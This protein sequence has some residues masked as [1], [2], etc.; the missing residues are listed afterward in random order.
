MAYILGEK[1]E[2]CF[3]CQA[4]AMGV[5]EESL[6]LHVT[7][8]G[9]VMLNRYP[10]INGHLMVVPRQH[11]SNLDALS[12]DELLDLHELLRRTVRIVREV[13]HPDGINIGMNLG[14]AAGAGLE[15]H[16]HYHVVP[17]YVGDHNAMSVLGDARV[18]PE[19]LEE[20]FRRYLAAFGKST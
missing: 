12:R 4:L 14:R 5:G 8:H 17:R 1:Q 15:D 16:L 19:S 3:V 10:Y 20:T 6:L 9:L 18:I 7:A 13:Q 2:G 11:V